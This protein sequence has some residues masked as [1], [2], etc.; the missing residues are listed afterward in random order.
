MEK[1]NRIVEVDFVRVICA[2]GIIVYHFYC[3]SSCNDKLFYLFENGLWGNVIVSIFFALSGGVLYLNNVEVSDYA[4]FYKK[5]WRSI[6][7]DF[8][9]VFLAFYLLNVI[10]YRTLFYGEKPITL[11]LSVIGMDGY[12]LEYIPNYY[13]VGEWFLGALIIMYSLY[14]ILSKLIKKK[15]IITLFVLLLLFISINNVDFLSDEQKFRSIFSCLISFYMG[16]IGAKYYKR[17]QSINLFWGMLVLIFLFVMVDLPFSNYVSE[18]LL[19]GVLLIVLLR[20]GRMR[21][22]GVISKKIMCVGELTYVV[23]LIQHKFINIAL[24]IKN[25]DTILGST[26]VLALVVATI[27]TVAFSFVEMKRRISKRIN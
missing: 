13:I 4:L 21:F 22:C 20:I 18:H 26:I 8:Y 19:A 5:R 1:K 3:H 16:M 25:P 10:K 15:P 2:I 24:K 12:L 23:F 11:L 9:I 7:P 6:F 27:F 17:L 14:P